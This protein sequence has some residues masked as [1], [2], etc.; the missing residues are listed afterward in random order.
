[1]GPAHPRLQLASDEPRLQPHQDQLLRS[2]APV[3]ERSRHE[4]RPSGRARAELL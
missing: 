3:F 1:M 4:L 2:V